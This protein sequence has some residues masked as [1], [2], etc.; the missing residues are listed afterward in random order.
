MSDKIAPALTP[1]EWAT[2]QRTGQ[3]DVYAAFNDGTSEGAHKTAA[4]CLHG[5]P[6]GFTREDLTHLGFAI[7]YLDQKLDEVRRRIVERGETPGPD[8]PNPLRSIQAR[9]EA[10][11]PP[12][13]GK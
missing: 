9:I 6:F 11:L 8:L 12:R 10:L 2:L 5:Q 4:V 13:E 3:L 7:L 1:E